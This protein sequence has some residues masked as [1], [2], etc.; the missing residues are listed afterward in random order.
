MR[1]VPRDLPLVERLIITDTGGTLRADLPAIPGARG[2]DLSSHEWF[3][4]VRR[5]GGRCISSA[6]T[7]AVAPRRNIFSVA[8]PVRA[9]RTQIVGYLVLQVGVES[10]LEWVGAG[11]AHA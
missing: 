3:Q 7:R 4:G 9:A 11:V 2:I 6:Y 1:A 10:L 8:V 5:D